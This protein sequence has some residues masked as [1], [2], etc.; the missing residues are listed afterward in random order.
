MTVA[1]FWISGIGSQQSREIA[2]Q[3]YD[4]VSGGGLTGGSR[5]LLRETIS[6]NM[7]TKIMETFKHETQ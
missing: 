2:F 7:P 1:A 4:K 3:Y 6:S 5:R